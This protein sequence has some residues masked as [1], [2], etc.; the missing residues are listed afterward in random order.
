MPC[1]VCID[2]YGMCLIVRK[3]AQRS[4]PADFL[5]R[6]WQRNHDGWGSVR[7]QAGRAVTTRGM[8]LDE[9][10]AHVAALPVREEVLIHLRRATHGPVNLEMAHPIEV[11][12]GIVLMHNGRIDSLAAPDNAVSDTYELARLL[13]QWLAPLPPPAASRVLRGEGFSRLLAPVIGDSMVVLA[14]SRGWLRLGRAWHLV[15]AQDWQDRAMHGIEVSNRH[16]WVPEVIAA[17]A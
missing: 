3:P 9:L 4:V 6:A 5:E 10:Q 7:W 8:S 1:P 15:T 13:G 17:A 2:K 14:D 12:P 11:C 16:T